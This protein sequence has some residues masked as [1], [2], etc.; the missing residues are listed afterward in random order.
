MEEWTI[1]QMNVKIQMLFTIKKSNMHINIIF[2]INLMKIHKEWTCFISR[3][4]R[5]IIKV[6]SVID[7]DTCDDPGVCKNLQHPWIWHKLYELII[8]FL[9]IYSQKYSQSLT[10]ESQDHKLMLVL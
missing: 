3:V 9:F 4:K 2:L 6:D 8:M 5:L 10:G 7:G 1:I